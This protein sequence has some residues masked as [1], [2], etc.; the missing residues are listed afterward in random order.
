M[1]V[2]T[3]TNSYYL[4]DGQQ[5]AD[6]RRS[7]FDQS[8]SANQQGF[9]DIFARSISLPLDLYNRFFQYIVS[10]G[11]KDIICEKEGYCYYNGDCST[12][13]N[14]FSDIVI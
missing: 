6:Q 4:S 12:K 13:L 14:L 2:N 8:S 9:I 1:F 10:L 7:F 3:K 5:L 11:D